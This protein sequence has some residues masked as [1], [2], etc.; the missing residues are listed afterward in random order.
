MIRSIGWAVA[1]ALAAGCSSP[2]GTSVRDD[3][4]GGGDGGAGA[5]QIAPTTATLG[6]GQTQT[7]SANRSV[8]WNVVEPGGGQIDGNGVYTAPSS[9]G[10]FHV[11]AATTDAPAE[12]ATATV[13][14]G[15]HGLALVAGTFGGRGTADGSGTAAR[16]WL[17]RGFAFDGAHYLYVGDSGA[18]RRIDV[19]S[20]AVTTL[21]GHVLGN[22]PSDGVGAAA[23]FGTAWGLAL[24]GAGG[25]YVS[26]E[27]DQTI[28]RIDL[29][30][31]AV[32]TVAGASG[33]AGFT[34]AMGASARF[35]SP[36]G[37]AFDAAG[38]RLFIAD[39]NNGAVRSY[40]PA[41]TMVT[42]LSSTLT[43]PDG[44]AFDGS[45]IL[46]VAD[47][48]ARQI[49][50]VDTS[51]KT[52]T[53]IAGAG[54]GFRD[55]PALSAHFD[56]IGPLALV[57]N[58]LY[59][60]D[61]LGVR[62]LDLDAQTV[63]TLQVGDGSARSI[64]GLAGDAGG[65]LLVGVQTSAAVVRVDP[66]NSM[67][68]VLA[69]PDGSGIGNVDGPGAAARFFDPGDVAVAP[70]GALLVSDVH[71]SEVRAIDLGSTTVSTLVGSSWRL[72]DV[73]GTGNAARTDYPTS[74][75]SDHAGNFYIVEP[76]DGV[77]RAWASATGALTTLAGRAGFP[78]VSDGTGA[79]ARF[80]QPIASCVDG[81]ALYVIEEANATL[82]KITLATGAVETV[83]GTGEEPGMMDGTGSAARFWTP[84]GIACDGAGHVYIAD[85]GNQAIRRFDTTSKVVDT[86]A[87]TLGAGGFT[88][89]PGNAA[90]FTAPA[91]MA[92]ANGFLYVVDDGYANLHL[93]KIQVGGSW[94][95]STIATSSAASQQFYGVAV[96]GAGTVYV[97][98]KQF[99]NSTI[100]KVAGDGTLQ[101]FAGSSATGNGLVI[102]GVGAAANFFGA[103]GMTVDGG[104][105]FVAEPQADVVRRIDLQS[106]QVTT[107]I[108]FGGDGVVVAGNGRGAS[109][110]RPG[111]MAFAG[112]ALFVADWTTLDH[113]TMP[114]A[115]LT[116]A[117][118]AVGYGGG[119][120]GV[121][122]DARL[123]AA[124]VTADGGV[125]YFTG[126]ASVRRFD[127][128]TGMVDT[129]AGN[130]SATG[131]DNGVRDAARFWTPRGLAADGAGNLYVSDTSNHTVRKLVIATGEV[132]TFAGAAGS[133]GA[134]DGVGDAARFD[135]PMGIVYDGAG[136][137]YVA[138]SGNGAIRRIEIATRA[139]STWVGVLGDK[140]LQPGAL[141]AHL[142]A[143]RG[144]AL[145]PDG[146]LV[147]TDEQAVLVVH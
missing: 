88:D 24:D 113:V 27:T 65:R 13:T 36:A 52:T 140:G 94:A 70:S 80:D 137:L 38:K 136:N 138:D 12:E 121:G 54:R 73:D 115:D 33:A 63:A 132:S 102:D 10:S 107:P 86:V 118:G 37:L 130:E 83:A 128:A 68:T 127:P 6:F 82:R 64:L 109:V 2:A 14:V 21:A 3:M 84:Q 100:S 142:N 40:D 60:G 48:G 19:G 139:V 42:T 78:G 119:M 28:R 59:V 71:N 91:E 1:I 45:H 106:A 34:N 95:V 56:W 25:L 15:D 58:G 4:G 96:D 134:I 9:P 147:I 93:R 29:A 17:P 141:P 131:S 20:G 92:Y 72:G 98:N 89:M 66:A 7:F 8:T 57:G 104:A 75:S 114:A 81:G 53:P 85:S 62:R 126:N 43:Q 55:G 123:N 76:N 129:L 117:A 22:G 111:G 26:D 35:H 110:D 11:H 125:L 30:T 99:G 143:P 67:T 50:A 47:A 39:A 23:Q 69:G 122:T 49:F 87:G 120:D 44:L 135:L 90:R 46:Y 41:T 145:L 103:A 79:A 18:V 51:A 101:P 105:L 124:G 133:F 116:I 112:G 108:G 16:F 31:E 61:T 32:T 97:S 74:V 77:V 5:L 144:L 146:G